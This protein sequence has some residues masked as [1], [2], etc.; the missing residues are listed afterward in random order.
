MSN[1]TG[2]HIEESFESIN[3]FTTIE[4]DD[5]SLSSWHVINPS[6]DDEIYSLDES[7]DSDHHHAVNT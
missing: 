5:D 7:T 2:A 6:D 4:K 3:V 1:R